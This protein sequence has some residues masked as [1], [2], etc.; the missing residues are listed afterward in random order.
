MHDALT[1]AY[2]SC[3]QLFSVKR[4]RVDVE[5]TGTHCVGETVV[6]VWRYR[7]CDDSWG[8]D[9][10]NCLVAEKLDASAILAT[11]SPL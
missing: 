6:D 4:Y 3:P 11:S 2:V 5:L 9:G 10:K 1:I 8:R 7:N